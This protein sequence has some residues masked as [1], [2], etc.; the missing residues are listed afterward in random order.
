MART[1][2]SEECSVCHENVSSAGAARS[3]H[4][5]KHVREGTLVALYSRV[6]DR[7]DYFPPEQAQGY[8]NGTVKNYANWMEVAA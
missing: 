6:L 7:T 5:R 2:S 3:S 4:K 8:L 1:Y